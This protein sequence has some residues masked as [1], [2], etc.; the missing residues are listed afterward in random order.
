MRILYESDL[1]G[2][3]HHGMAYRIYQFSCEFKEHGHEVMIVASS[4]SHAR[5]TNPNVKNIL[6]NEI[7]DGIIYK[8][9]KT[10]IY[11]GNGLGRIFHMLV[12][13]LRLWFY[14]KRIA[15]EFKP[16]VVI[17][18]G[19]TPLDFFGCKRIAKKSRAKI[20]LEVG[21]L[22]PLSP[23]ELGGYSKRHP[24]IKFIQYFEDYS[25]KHADSL[26]SLLPY[27]R[28]Y[29][30]FHGLNE[31]KFN[32]IPNGIVIKDWDKQIELS[33]THKKLLE[34]LRDK[35]FCIIGYTGAHGTANSLKT[36]ID[37]VAKLESEQVALV[38][39]GA[40]SEKEALIKYVKYNSIPNIFFLPSIKKEEI[41]NCLKLMDVLYIGLQKQSLF[42]FGISPNKMFDY[43]MAGK[44]IIQAIDAGNNIVEEVNCGLYAEPEN[45][46][47]IAD[48]IR[49]IKDMPLED[50]EKMGKNGRKF[51]LEN[52]SY[53]VLT[54]KYLSIINKIKN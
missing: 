12:Y 42:R 28:D 54:D 3:R 53:G 5:H 45:V 13:N 32:Y 47:A 7:I 10:P 18:S 1:A 22:W 24:F 33:L 46:N 41:P 40:G 8:W 50:R 31:E 6:T 44:P 11:S 36:V 38:L 49:K 39:V 51:V 52:H 34:E 16:D 20:I 29:M 19:V 26:I 43:M 27:A 2:S 21:D 37:A 15:N 9:I 30:V 35:G 4:F 23:I 25:F 17:A 14:A 48:A